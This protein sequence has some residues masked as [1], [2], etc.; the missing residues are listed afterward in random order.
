MSSQA[1]T[2][3]AGITAGLTLATLTYTAIQDHPISS[4][5][6]GALIGIVLGAAAMKALL[7]ENAKVTPFLDRFGV[8]PYAIQ[9]AEETPMII[10]SAMA[11]GAI[12]GVGGTLIYVF[13][14]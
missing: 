11:G 1:I 10:L 3:G 8:A 9:K 5:G 6:R 13:L 14:G 7:Y 4:I 2:W 12:G